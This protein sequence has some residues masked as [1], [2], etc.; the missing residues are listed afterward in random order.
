[1]AT[2]CYKI[3][4]VGDAEVGKSTFVQRHLTG[5]WHREYEA[6]IGV[7]VNPLRFITNYGDICFNVWDCG[8]QE[9]LSS[10]KEA[11][12]MADAALVFC[13]LERRET[14]NNVPLW[15]EK[16]K[17]VV[18]DV[19]VVVCANKFDRKVRITRLRKLGH[20]YYEISSKTGYEYVRPFLA[21]AR[22]LTGHNDLCF[23]YPGF[24]EENEVVEENEEHEVVKENEEHEVVRSMRSMRS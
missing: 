10:L 17:D 13:D 12:Y 19:H 18:P 24:S 21:L 23:Y 11:Y 16:V 6:T 22:F 3:V 20:P 8:G 1:M 9:K 15:V 14:Q 2:P 7:E 4:L 5:E